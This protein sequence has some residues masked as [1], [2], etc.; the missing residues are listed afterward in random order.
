[1]EKFYD[2]GLAWGWMTPQAAVLDINGVVDV[3]RI[4]Y[5]AIGND[6]IKI[7]RTLS[8]S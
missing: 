8:L 2:P 4:E 6:E 7:K 3:D 5:Q 1:M